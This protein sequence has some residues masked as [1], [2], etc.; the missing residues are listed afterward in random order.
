MG[1]SS[2]PFELWD[3]VVDN[4]EDDVHAL[5]QCALVCKT[6]ACL[7]QRHLFS[8]LMC[9]K[10]S[11]G[12]PK[13]LG[14]FLSDKPNLAAD[15]G[16]LILD[17]QTIALPVLQLIIDLLPNLRTLDLNSVTIPQPSDAELTLPMPRTH[18]LVSFQWARCDATS[19]TLYLVLAH[20]T[21]IASLVLKDR[22]R[23]GRYLRICKSLRKL[24]P[25]HLAVEHISYT[26][27]PTSVLS[28]LVRGSRMA[29]TVESIEIVST[30]GI[31][32]EMLGDVLLA[33]TSLRHLHLR[34]R[35]FMLWWDDRSRDIKLAQCT[36]LET[37][38]FTLHSE[39]PTQENVEF[40]LLQWLT[41]I[42]YLPPSLRAV[43]FRVY[44]LPKLWRLASSST[45]LED[46]FWPEINRR[47]LDLPPHTRLEVVSAVDVPAERPLAHDDIVAAR[48]FIRARLPRLV[49]Q[50]R[51]SVFEDQ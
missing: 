30:A 47:V 39:E 42:R 7:S 44:G 16:T 33:V 14:Q 46:E 43:R 9:A 15:V 45:D 29:T 51:L 18:R 4:L 2:L 25:S 12:T 36:S 26:T 49:E 5:K 23:S 35:S 19:S 50:G 6:W 31:S 17:H 1:A 3:M 20:F 21:S 48:M 41:G 13:D 22:S 11:A 28:D 8:L 10:N 38:Q 34:S 24:V 27:F 40:W 32:L 37:V